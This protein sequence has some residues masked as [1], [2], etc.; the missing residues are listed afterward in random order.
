MGL[1]EQVCCRK[2]EGF[3]VEACLVHFSEIKE[4]IVAKAE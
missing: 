1:D 4:I 3:E 2:R